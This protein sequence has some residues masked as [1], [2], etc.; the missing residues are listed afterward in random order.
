LQIRHAVTGLSSSTDARLFGSDDYWSRR[1]PIDGTVST[2]HRKGSGRPLLLCLHAGTAW[3][4]AGICSPFDEYW[5]CDRCDTVGCGLRGGDRA[6]TGLELVAGYLVAWVVRKARRVAARA[7]AEVDDAV[8]VG[9]ER[10]HDLINAKLGGDS[11]LK[12]LEAEAAERGEAT[13][14][15]RE[16]VRLAVEDAVEAD[17]AFAARLEEILANLQPAGTAAVSVQDHAVAAGGDVRIE[18]ELGGVAAGVIHGHV[19][20][21]NPSRPGPASA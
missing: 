4:R 19:T 9:I 11:A 20:P 8:N 6:M 21:G 10:L 17:H 16:R 14:R 3:V 2:A 15:T 12:R 5:S 7:D 1:V 18:A 13:Q